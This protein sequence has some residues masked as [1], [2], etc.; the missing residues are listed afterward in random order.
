MM[1]LG[2]GFLTVNPFKAEMRPPEPL[3]LIEA[4][5]AEPI[6]PSMRRL[7]NETYVAQDVF[8]NAKLWLARCIY[9]ETKRPDEQ[10]LVAWVVRNRVETAFRGRTT[11]QR[12][13][14]DPY[15]FSAFNPGEYSR[16][17]FMSLKPSYNERTW[18]QA[19]NI[20]EE[21]LLADPL[22]RPFALNTRHFY[23]ERS[24]PSHMRH[25]RW[26]KNR[27]PVNLA[28]FDIDER[29]FRFYSNIS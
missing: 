12:V 20:A 26:A 27:V 23:S 8:E 19:L 7:H 25:P 2:A 14:L 4:R 15:Q 17:H 1:T 9:S 29:R 13:V 21:V 18:Q 24:M 22:A 6:D 28:D 16:R 10:R 5:P 11:Y 3:E